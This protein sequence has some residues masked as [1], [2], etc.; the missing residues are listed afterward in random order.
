MGP[1]PILFFLDPQA[2]SYIEGA[3]PEITPPTKAGFDTL[4][5]E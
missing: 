3:V 4:G 1:S 5:R 2:I